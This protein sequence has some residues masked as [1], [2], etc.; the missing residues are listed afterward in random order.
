TGGFSIL[1]MVNVCADR[2]ARADLF[3]HL[4]PQ[5]LESVPLCTADEELLIQVE[6]TAAGAVGELKCVL[7]PRAVREEYY[8]RYD[9][10]LAGWLPAEED[11]ATAQGP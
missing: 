6:E 1:G 9:P 3:G 7:V 8:G 4:R 5:Y 2:R 11:A 10:E